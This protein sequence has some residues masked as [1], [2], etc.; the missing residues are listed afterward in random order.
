M[1]QNS[2]FDIDDYNI[3]KSY[4]IIDRPTKAALKSTMRMIQHGS[5]IDYRK[6]YFT[7]VRLSNERTLCYI[8][9]CKFKKVPRKL[10]C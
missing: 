6:I 4:A 8:L 5:L 9:T 7:R 2:L 10:V 1:E 3:F